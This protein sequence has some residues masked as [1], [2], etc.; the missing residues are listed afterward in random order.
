MRKPPSKPQ[1]RRLRRHNVDTED[2]SP[3]EERETE[4]VGPPDDKDQ[5]SDK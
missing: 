4:V 2:E 1:R 3:F 5:P